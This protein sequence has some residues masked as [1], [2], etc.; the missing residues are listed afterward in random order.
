M[1]ELD[2]SNCELHLPC[3]A[4]VLSAEVLKLRVEVREREAARQAWAIRAAEESARADALLEA[5][6]KV[7]RDTMAGSVFAIDDLGMAIEAAKV[8]H[9]E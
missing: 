1:S 6:E 2:L 3:Q 4:S 7:Y 9:G 5:A 8:K